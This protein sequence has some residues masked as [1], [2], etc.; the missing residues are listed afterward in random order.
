MNQRTAWV[1]SNGLIGMDNQSIGLAEA[2]GLNYAVKRCQPTSPWKH[3][4]AEL[5]WRPM[6]HLTQDSDSLQ[7]PWPDVVIGTG[8]LNVALSIAIKRASSGLTQNIRIQHPHVALR[9]F[10]AIV[11]PEHDHCRGAQVISTLGAV[12]RVTQAQLN[13]AA[14]QFAARLAHLPRPITTVLLGGSNSAYRVD[15]A[16][17]QRMAH[18]LMQSLREQGGSVLMTPSRRTDAA[19]ITPMAA[20]LQRY[21][22]V[23]WN[24]TGD[25]PYFSFLA[26][27]DRI[28]VTADSVN[29]A[30]EACFTG[31]PVF[32]HGLTG[33]GNKFERFHRGLLQRGCTRPLM[34]RFSHWEY[35]PLAETDR[36]AQHI[37]RILGW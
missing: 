37:T 33:E 32:V 13:A 17:T 12:N 5:C 20:V 27:A 4:P 36:A 28:V 29:M 35:Q 30:S 11:A 26:V 2:L 1:L 18:L 10:D 23:I 9:H 16:F 3:L 7:P 25:N 6:Q 8:R 22:G 19:A 34:D 15:V 31:K 24:G 21:P 14:A